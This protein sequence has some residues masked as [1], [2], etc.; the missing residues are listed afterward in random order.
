MQLVEYPFQIGFTLIGYEI[1]NCF[2]FVVLANQQGIQKLPSVSS[3][4]YH[5]LDK[6]IFL[7]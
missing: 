7:A 5:S 3:V 4:W 1:H 2:T 6:Q